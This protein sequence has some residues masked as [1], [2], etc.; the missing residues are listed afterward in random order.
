MKLFLTSA[1]LPPEIT[2]AFLELLGRK[3]EETTVCF[4]ATAAEP[5]YDKWFVEK[6]K[7]R[8]TELRFEMIEIDLKYETEKSLS[9]KLANLDVVFVEGGNTFYLM[10][11]IK[12]SGFDKAVK[13][14]LN[15]GGLYVGVSAGSY[16]ACPDISSALWKQA[17]DENQVELKDFKG[18][19]LVDFYVSSH[20]I[21][22]HEAIIN[23]NKDKVSYPIFALTDSQAVLV[24]DRGIRFIGPGE[25]KKFYQN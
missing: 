3:P 7:A 17:E 21:L 10:K 19:D 18:L 12:E 5:Y 9:G 25:F 2:E 22:E 14:F 11:Y 8:L 13:R 15:T 23:E 1:G 24:D 4:I 16:V 20:Y 6:D